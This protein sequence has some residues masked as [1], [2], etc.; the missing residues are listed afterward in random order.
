MSSRSLNKVMLIGNLTRDV[1][2]R[3]TPSGT[4]VATFGLATNRSWSAGE[5]G[6]R[7]EETQFHRIVAWSK[8]AEIC[9]Q[10]LFKG[11]RIYVEGRLQ[12][13]KFTGQDGQQREI[14]EIVAE[15]MMILDTRNRDGNGGGSYSEEEFVSTDE[16]S[17]SD[18]TQTPV[19]T[20]GD[21]ATP[22]K[23]TKKAAKTEEK[24]ETSLSDEVNVEDIP[25]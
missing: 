25:F 3:Y 21:D 7:Q 4:A 11:R 16:A 22:K 10:L 13:R 17:A 19:V 2:V 6:D 5:G 14:T 24:T 9:G 20:T 23:T 8:L 18:M 12:T 1:D 15:N